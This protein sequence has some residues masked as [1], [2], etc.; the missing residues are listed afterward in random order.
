MALS[1]SRKILIGMLATTVALV[2]GVYAYLALPSAEYQPY[3]YGQA[4]R[5]KLPRMTMVN[6][7]SI[8]RELLGTPSIEVKSIGILVYD[9]VDTLEAVAPMVVFS[10]LMSVKLEY[11]GR[12][13]GIVSTTLADLQVERAIDEVDQLDVLIVPGGNRAGLETMLD[14]SSLHE[15]LRRIDAGSKL[16]AAVGDG[17]VLLAK[18]GLLRD[19]TIAFGWPQGEANAAALGSRFVAAQYT[20]DDKY[21]TSVGGAA[22]IDQS[23]AMLQAIAGERHLEAAMLDLEYDPVPPLR[24]GTAATAPPDVLAALAALT[25]ARDGLTLLDATPPQHAESQQQRVQIGHPGLRGLL[26][27]RRDR[28]ARRAV[29]DRGCSGSTGPLRRQGRD[30]VRAH[31]PASD[32]LDRRCRRPRPAAGAGWRRWDLGDDQRPLGAGLDSRHRRP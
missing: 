19:R 31:P 23:L 21:W 10:E 25:W 15:W 12:R 6:H 14:D 27:T 2:A 5:E 30:Q 32:D 3:S 22:A 18:A 17:S 8:M 20:H 28:A 13:S 29:R 1:R 4:D 16:T 9:G 26:H 11:V 7:E 24:G